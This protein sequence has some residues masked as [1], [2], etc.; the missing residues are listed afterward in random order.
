MGQQLM[1]H[2]PCDPSDFRDHLTHDPS[3]HSLL[4]TELFNSADDDFFNSV[5]TSSAHVLQ[6]YLPDQTDIPY[7]LR[8]RHHDMTMI[9]KTKFLHDSDFIIRML[10]KYSY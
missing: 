5:K 3:T 1:T 9:N 8:A 2:D 4:C 7:R 6:P 10:Y